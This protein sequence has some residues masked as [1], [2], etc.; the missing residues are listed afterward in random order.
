M[1][2]HTRPADHQHDTHDFPRLRRKSYTH[3]KWVKFAK[4]FSKLIM[5]I[6]LGCASSKKSSVV[7]YSFI[8]AAWLISIGST[9]QSSIVDIVMRASVRLWRRR[10]QGALSYFRMLGDMFV[11][12]FLY[13]EGPQQLLILEVNYPVSISELYLWTGS[14]SNPTIEVDHWI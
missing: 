6:F 8:A 12:C 11:R 7:A 4:P 1:R 9:N 5:L 14:V 13:C 2:F 10:H 3:A